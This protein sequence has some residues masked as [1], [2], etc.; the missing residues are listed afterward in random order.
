MQKG[1]LENRKV[2]AKYDDLALVT[3][4]EEDIKILSKY[5]ADFDLMR[6]TFGKTF[7]QDEA[8]SYIK[9]NF[10]FD[11]K[12]KFSPIDY[13]D[14]IIGFGGIFKFDYKSYELGYIIAK[15]HWGRGFATKIALAQI[16]FI[17]SHFK[18]RVV[19]TTHPKNIVSQKILQK[20]GLR[21]KKDIFLEY[22]GKRKLFVLD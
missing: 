15:E 13:K 18:T 1:I 9:K 20:C 10:N 16:E 14:K 11:G 12:L 19:A 5:F 22:R 4:K 3:T 2:I 17:Q 6:Y 8:I 21:Y 7:S